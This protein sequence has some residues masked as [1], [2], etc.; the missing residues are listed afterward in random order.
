[1]AERAGFEP[2]RPVPQPTR[3]PGVPIRPLWHL[4][5]QIV[6]NRVWSVFVM[7]VNED[8]GKLSVE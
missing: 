6:F 8:S 4:S 2:A 7:H 5:Y 3:F 1:M